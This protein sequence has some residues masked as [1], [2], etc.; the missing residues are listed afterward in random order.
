MKGPIFFNPTSAAP[1]GNDAQCNDNAC[2]LSLKVNFNL[3]EHAPKKIVVYLNEE[4]PSTWLGNKSIYQTR[5][6]IDDGGELIV[7]AP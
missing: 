2:D 7:L 1:S 3:L 5:M 6:A 4:Y